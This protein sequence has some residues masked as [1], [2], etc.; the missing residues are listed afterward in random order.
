METKE[1]DFSL[2]TDRSSYMNLP[3]EFR[4]NLQDYPLKQTRVETLCQEVQTEEAIIRHETGVQV[5]NPTTTTETSAQIQTSM[6]DVSS[7]AVKDL[8]DVDTSTQFIK[9]MN[10][11]VQAGNGYPTLDTSAQTNFIQTSDTSAQSESTPPPPTLDISLQTQTLGPILESALVKE[12][13][14]LMQNTIENLQSELRSMKESFL[15]STAPVQSEIAKVIEGAQALCERQQM[16]MRQ[17]KQEYSR[18]LDL[19]NQAQIQLRGEIEEVRRQKEEITRAKT[20]EVIELQIKVAQ[21]GQFSE[22]TN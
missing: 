21:V 20:E 14:K 17:M 19:Q 15:S 5:G 1:R 3:D 9:L 12:R 22:F 8:V 2:P 7:Q 6:V 10:I 11:S 13:C 18:D 4:E 16:D